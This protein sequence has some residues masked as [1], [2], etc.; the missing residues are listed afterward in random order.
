VLDFVPTSIYSP[1]KDKETIIFDSVKL[2]IILHRWEILSSRS[3]AIIL[4]DLSPETKIKFPFPFISAKAET[5][6][7]W[8]DI[9]FLH[10]SY[11]QQY[12]DPLVIPL[13]IQFF[14]LF[15]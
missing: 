6:P 10:L 15:L 3:Q 12:I 13:K 11:Y 8:P 7:L 14:Y 1:Y 4:P 2:F 9:A 5:D